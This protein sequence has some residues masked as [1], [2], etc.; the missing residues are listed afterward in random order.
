VVH[1]E[2]EVAVSFGS[3]SMQRD[4]NN[5]LKLV[6]NVGRDTLKGA[7]SSS[8]IRRRSKPAATQ[9]LSRKAGLAPPLVR[10]RGASTWRLRVATSGRGWLALRPLASGS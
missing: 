2:R 1:G 3:L 7:P 8:G 9:R 10:L 5:N 6:A 4:Q